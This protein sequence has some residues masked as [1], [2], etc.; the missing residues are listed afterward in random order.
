MA[1]L[2]LGSILDKGKRAE[3]AP[4]Q[5]EHIFMAIW[6]RDSWE[7]VIYTLQLQANNVGNNLKL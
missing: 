2:N 6:Y 7:V 5:R 3:I 4:D 1:L